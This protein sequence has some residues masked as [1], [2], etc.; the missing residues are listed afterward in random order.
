MHFIRRYFIAGLL[1]WLPV[2][3]TLLVIRFLVDIF[4]NTMLMIPRDYRPDVILGMNIPGLG[5]I[6]SVAV[7]FIT[8]MLITNFLGHRLVIFWEAIVNKIPLVRS[9]YS[10]VKQITETIFSSAGQSFRKAYLIEFPRKGI[11]T[12][13]FQTGNS[14]PEIETVLGEKMLN[15][16]VPTTP[17]PTSGF[18]VMVPQDE[19]KELTIGIEQALKYVI[20][21]GV[22]QPT[23]N[24]DKKENAG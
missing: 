12:I 23:K 19:A 11:W 3:V 22:V 4:D 18:F 7:V 21:I 20:S 6:I 9:I 15:L 5:V 16:Y 17:N 24:N 13:G 8:G 2:W 10:A 1:V 14:A